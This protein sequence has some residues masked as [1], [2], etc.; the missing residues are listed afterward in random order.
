MSRA[1]LPRLP[2]LRG[3][4]GK[5]LPLLVLGI[6]L[7]TTLGMW[8]MLHNGFSDGA[9][10]LFNEKAGGIALELDKRL[11]T[12]EQ[13]LK[14]G[15]GLLSAVGDASRDEWRRY[16][17][18]LQLDQNHPGILG[19]GYSIWLTPEEKEVNVGKIRSQGFPEYTIRPPGRR[20]NYSSIIYLEPFTWRNERAFGY[21]M[22]TEPNRR[23]AMEKARDEGITTIASRIILVQ[24][25]EKDK[26]I[27]LLMYLPVYRRGAPT[28]SVERRREALRGFVYSPIRM[29]DFVYGTLG[30][31]PTD[32]SFEIFDGETT[33]P[34]KL[35][36]SSLNSEKITLPAGYRPKMKKSVR[37]EEYGR[38]WTISF[39]SLPSFDREFNR[40]SSVT[41][42]VGG[43]LVSILLSVIT[44]T[45]RS[46]RD[47]AL[48]LAQNMTKELRDGEEKLRLLLN[49]IGEGVYGIDTNG[50]CTFCNPAALQILGYHSQ[51]E[52][53]GKNMHDLIH[54]SHEDSSHFPVENCEIF[55]AFTNN[56]G[57]HVEGQV[58]WRGD[59]ASL[60]V[61]Y[62][63][64]P[65]HKEGEVI[66]AV[67]TFTDITTRKRSE[68]ALQEQAERLREEIAERRKGEELLRL[69][70]QELELLNS[71]LEQRV[72]HE[73]K[74]NREKDQTLM[75][76]EKMA[77]LGQLAAG[78]AHEINNPMGYITS[79]LHALSEYFDQLIRYDRF[80]QENRGELSPLLL[81]AITVSR[82]SLEVEQI[83]DD[84]TDLI[85]ESLNGAERVTRIVQDLKSFSRVDALESEQVLLSSCMES[86]LTIVYN[87]LKYAATIRKEYESVPEIL[88][89]PGQLNQ[90]FMN[91]LVNAGQAIDPP[92]DI[93]LR[94][95]HDASSVYASV[96]DTGKGIPEAIRERIFD[97]FFTTK[98]VGK[99]T[100]LGL[101]ISYEI[102]KKHRG[103]LLVE[104]TIGIGTT[105]T[106]RLPI[107]GSA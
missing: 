78:V 18:S 39:Q 24:E 69:Q 36:F 72:A 46:T 79:N 95:W 71:R 107:E 15:V 100:G 45:L 70:Q 60:P 3:G 66:G 57:C 33:T 9:R 63:S 16:V 99:G 77:S 94:C 92:G 28:D 102:V 21:D 26:Q 53:L 49:T 101:S 91:L 75:H 19:V 25:S 106:V 14:G 89:H 8:L 23:A 12:H 81:E 88:C 93:G 96:S 42:L 59:G 54:H 98:E 85:S 67:V 22:F 13:L 6:S 82:E 84:G 35:M 76:N 5:L 17:S 32:I 103:E 73:V 74:K 86:A 68:A 11:H 61:E 62:W 80:L 65:Q 48:T 97:P 50:H 2:G 105:F 52:L 38:S 41:T 56:T 27:G 51:E 10:H 40:T 55:K 1:A 30:T 58:F 83:L 7:V 43:I 90:V 34:E 31:L 87:E 64:V 20:P 29:K 4:G 37:V 44:F 104:S 47:T